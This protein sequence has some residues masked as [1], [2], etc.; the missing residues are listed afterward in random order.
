MTVSIDYQLLWWLIYWTMKLFTMCPHELVMS[1]EFLNILHIFSV[2]PVNIVIGG[3]CTL[4]CGSFCMFSG[5]YARRYFKIFIFRFTE[6]RQRFSITSVVVS[7]YLAS[8]FI[9]FIVKNNEKEEETGYEMKFSK[10]HQKKM[11]ET[12]II[13]QSI[14]AL[15]NMFDIT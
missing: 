6:S 13:I 2:A 8:F 15:W 11:I 4:C 5:W 3:L 10:N 12:A 1:A 14:W 9:L 7:I